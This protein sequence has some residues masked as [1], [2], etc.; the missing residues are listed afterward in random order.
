MKT[1]WNG[2]NVCY[3][4]LRDLT[5]ETLSFK[6]NCSIRRSGMIEEEF[7]MF[8]NQEIELLLKKRDSKSWTFS[9]LKI[10]NLNSNMVELVL[11]F[12][13]SNE[14]DNERRN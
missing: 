6:A 5:F 2:Q 14:L 7:T 12:L 3:R 9:L 13:Y 10:Y 8:E 1:C 11:A 4:L